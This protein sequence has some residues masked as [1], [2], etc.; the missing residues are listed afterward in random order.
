MSKS[1]LVV[2]GNWA[3][4]RLWDIDPDRCTWENFYDYVKYAESL[5][6]AEKTIMLFD[7]GRSSYR[8]HIL[9]SYKGNRHHPEDQITQFE[10]LKENWKNYARDNKNYYWLKRTNTEADDWACKVCDVLKDVDCTI[11]LLSIDHDWFQ[12]LRGR[13]VMQL[14]YSLEDKI[15]KLVTEEDATDQIGFPANRWAELAAFIGDPG[16]GVPPTSITKTKGLKYLHDHHSLM[17]AV[18]SEPDCRAEAW[19][20]LRNYQLTKLDPSIIELTNEEEE[21]IRNWATA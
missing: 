2:D 11:F 12:L 21:A 20:I 1:I 18:S 19:K 15:E 4:H 13:K 6:D 5:C 9:A 17:G 7:D 16:D 8:T 10:I 3:M 14:R